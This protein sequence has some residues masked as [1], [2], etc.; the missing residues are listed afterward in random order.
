MFITKFCVIE[1][2]AA[3]EF[4]KRRFQTHYPNQPL[5]VWAL[6]TSGATGGICYWLACYP[7]DVVKSRI[8]LRVTPPEGS[9]IQYIAHELRA[10]VAEGGV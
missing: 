9:P 4:T 8:Q 5:P 2:H 10:I 7:L 6:L 3:F 1:F